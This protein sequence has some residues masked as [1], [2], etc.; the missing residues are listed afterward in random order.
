MHMFI[1]ICSI[2]NNY[3]QLSANSVETASQIL[4][5]LGAVMQST[6]QRMQD[7]WSE[8]RDLISEEF[9]Q[10]VTRV[11]SNLIEAASLLIHR[12]NVTLY[13]QTS[14]KRTPLGPLKVSDYDGLKTRKHY[15]G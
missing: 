10:T 14:R 1:N 6:H 13:S 4:H 8:A 3:L 9:I 7:N 5:K 15:R 11:T 12:S 2:C